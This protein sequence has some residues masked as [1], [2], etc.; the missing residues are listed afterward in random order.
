M[1]SA[2]DRSAA[3]V[4]RGRSATQHEREERGWQGQENTRN[5]S[6][7]TGCR[8][9]VV[10][11]GMEG[12][13]VKGRE[14]RRLLFLRCVNNKFFLLPLP[15]RYHQPDQ[16]GFLERDSG[17]AEDVVQTSVEAQGAKLTPLR[18]SRMPVRPVRALYLRALGLLVAHYRHCSGCSSCWPTPVNR[19]G[20]WRC[21]NINGSSQQVGV[22]V[23]L[24]LV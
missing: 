2:G 14:V 8:N 4:N 5:N 18:C 21:A 10:K 9:C 23:T 17:Q 3:L 19:P 11:M 6:R 20:G 16:T 1:E 7:E 15:E 22:S 13:H 24:K 12:G